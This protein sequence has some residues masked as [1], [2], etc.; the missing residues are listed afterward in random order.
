MWCLMK[1]SCVTQKWNVTPSCFWCDHAEIKTVWTEDPRCA[2]KYIIFRHKGFF[3]PRSINPILSGTISYVFCKMLAKKVTRLALFFLSFGHL[4]LAG[5]PGDWNSL[6]DGYS[7][8][9]MY[10]HIDR[11]NWYTVADCIS[12]HNWASKPLPTFKQNIF[13]KWEAWDWTWILNVVSFRLNP[14]QKIRLNAFMFIMKCGQC[15]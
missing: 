3:V 11:D 8:C 14:I 1:G 15:T 10:K 5:K 12:W 2:G 9:Q 13:L 7:L 4:T 6:S